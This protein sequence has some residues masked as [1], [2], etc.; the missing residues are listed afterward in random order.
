MATVYPWAWFITEPPDQRWS[1][2]FPPGVLSS[3]TGLVTLPV[4]A[5]A[6]L[7]GGLL[8][9]RS[10]LLAIA[11][12][13]GSIAIPTLAWRQ[14]EIWAPQ[15]LP[16]DIAL[17]IV[18]AWYPRRV[19][20][21]G[22]G[23][24]LAVLVAF[25]AARSIPGIEGGTPS[26][27]G[28]A[29][30]LC[31]AVL[32]GTVARQARERA[33]EAREQAA[34]ELISA[35]RLR[36]ARDLHDVVAHSLGVITLQAGAAGRIMR[37][38][39]DAAREAVGT[40]EKV[41]RETLAGLRRALSALRD[42]E[43]GPLLTTDVDD[44]LTTTRAAGMD[45]E[46]TQLGRPR[47]LPPEIDTTAYR[48]V[49]EAVANVMRHAST[50]ACRVLI[51]FREG[52]LSVEVVDDGAGRGRRFDPGFGLIGMRERVEA[53]GGTLAT[54]PRPEGGFR[55]SAYLPLPGGER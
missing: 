30:S 29:L 42:V 21:T 37:T 5:A 36:I 46:V 22:A 55:V 17:A 24:A 20:L 7:A 1:S 39:P 40:I 25:L 2:L 12:L 4:A 11:L 26:E 19:A 23:L 32:I 8:T 50:D 6:A 9:R 16:V 27:P 43:P 41:G 10:P 44:L 18:A 35:E 53:L 52:D 14:P 34:A 51:D 33:A 49:Q 45:V 47:A 28:M 54:G 48:I 13:L 31:T 38:Q 15:I 3:A